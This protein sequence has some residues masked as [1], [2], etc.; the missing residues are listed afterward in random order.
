MLQLQPR[1]VPTGPSPSEM[2]SHAPSQASAGARESF[3]AAASLDALLRFRGPR[4][5]AAALEAAYAA[6][7]ARTMRGPRTVGL[8]FIALAYAVG[9][10]VYA[11]SNTPFESA[12]YWLYVVMSC[13]CLSLVPLVRA[14]AVWCVDLATC[15]GAA[16]VLFAFNFGNKAARMCST[17]DYTALMLFVAFPISVGVMCTPRWR[18]Y[19]AMCA[20]HATR[21]CVELAPLGVVPRFGVCLSALLGTVLLYVQERGSREQF[22]SAPARPET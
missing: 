16:L 22:V 10:G 17:G 14:R 13:A 1:Q 21:A 3:N 9:I 18:F 20:A 7:H 5:E 11:A 4:A 8:V 12:D 6:S 15:A 2:W 19:A